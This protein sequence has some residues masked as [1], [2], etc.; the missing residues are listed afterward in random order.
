MK[1]AMKS[2]P[3]TGSGKSYGKKKKNGTDRKMLLYLMDTAAV[4]RPLR[5]QAE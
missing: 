4:G 1:N 3:D 2:V 5:V